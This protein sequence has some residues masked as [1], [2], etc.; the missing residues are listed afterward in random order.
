MIRQI[1]LR[2]ADPA[3]PAA[4][5]ATAQAAALRLSCGAAAI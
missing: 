5:T 4:G 2:E 1:V 3:A